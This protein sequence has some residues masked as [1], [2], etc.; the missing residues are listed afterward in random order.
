MDFWGEFERYRVCFLGLG[1]GFGASKRLAFFLI[2][3]L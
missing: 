2:V 3:V 1:L